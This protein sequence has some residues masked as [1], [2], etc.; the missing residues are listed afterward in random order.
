[1]AAAVAGGGRRG[2][3]RDRAGP[4]V[5]GGDVRV[6]HQGEVRGLAQA[7]VHCR[8]EKG[9]FLF[10][11]LAERW[12]LTLI[13]LQVTKFTTMTGCNKEP[14]ELCAPAG[15]GFREVRC[16]YIILKLKTIIYIFHI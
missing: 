6:H 13:M 8:Q 11:N 14:T 15:C 4:D 7:G 3:V 10:F 12:I 5:Q 16:L 2:G 9:Q 1:M